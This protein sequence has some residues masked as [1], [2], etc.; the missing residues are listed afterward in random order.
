MSGP[1][2]GNRLHVD[3]DTLNQCINT[4]HS[5][6]SD[7]QQSAV[8]YN[9]TQSNTQGSWLGQAANAFFQAL[10]DNN[11]IGNNGQAVNMAQTLANDLA[12][13]MASADQADDQAAAL[14][15][16]LGA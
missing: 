2:A 16:S 15:K 10:G 1:Q 6:M 13:I 12:Q 11:V 7:F 4:I 3:Y 8:G 9:N 14:F 5:A